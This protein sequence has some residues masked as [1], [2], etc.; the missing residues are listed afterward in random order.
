MNASIGTELMP[1]HPH[2]HCAKH[3]LMFASSLR[4][5]NEV[6]K[7]T[8]IVKLISGGATGTQTNVCFV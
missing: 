8:A 7:T 2:I 6:F 3:H 1:S 4:L 5:V